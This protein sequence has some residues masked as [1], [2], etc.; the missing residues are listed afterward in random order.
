M[1]S[2]TRLRSQSR[3]AAG[4]VS[5]VPRAVGG[6]GR[7]HRPEHLEGR[8]FAPYSLPHVAQ[9]LPIPEPSWGWRGWGSPPLSCSVHLPFLSLT[10]LSSQLCYRHGCVWRVLGE[11]RSTK[12]RIN[13][14]KKT[15]TDVGS[16][17]H[18]V[19]PILHLAAAAPASPSTGILLSWFRVAFSW[20]FG[21]AI[22]ALIEINTL[23]C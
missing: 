16:A 7:S 10:S 6:S 2:A 19:A 18:N 11:G 5:S 3:T 14:N 9:P 22:T 15:K 12:N 8:M 4:M 23:S 21:G 13:K 20:Q 1:F 17:V